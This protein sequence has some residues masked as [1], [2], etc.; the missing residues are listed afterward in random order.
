[1]KTS[2]IILCAFVL[3]WNTTT[4]LAQRQCGIEAEK[5]A[6]IA[7][8]PTW[9]QRFEAQRSSLQGIADNYKLQHG[10]N[11]NAAERTTTTGTISPCPIIFHIVIS[12]ADL[13]L[14]GGYSG[15]QQRVNSQM[16]VINRDFNRQNSDSS[17]IPAGWKSRYGN[18][19]IQ[20][21]LA[22][23][24]PDG[25]ATPGYEVLITNTVFY[26]GTYGDY[27]DAKYSSSGGLDAWDNTK[28]INVWCLNFTNG[29]LGITTPLSFTGSGGVPIA[30]MGIC[31]HFETLGKRASPSD[32]YI[33]TGWISGSDSDYY[34]QGRTLTHEMGHYFEIWHT[35]GDDGG[36][37]PWDSGSDDGLA[38]TPP[39]GDS[40]FYNWPDTIPGGTYYDNCR[41]DT[42]G[43]GDIDTQNYMYGI[44]S[45]DYLNYTDDVAMHMF[46]TM[47]AAAM[48]SMAL[49]PPGSGATGA[50]G[51]G[52]VGETYSVTQ[53]PL[54]LQYPPGTV[55]GV[56]QLEMNTDLNIF[57][58]PATGIINIT[59][60][61]NSGALQ[62]ISVTNMIGQELQNMN[63]SG[64][65][66]NDYSIDLSGMSKG[67]YFVR[68]NFA[69]GIVTR[70]IVLQ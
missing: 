8:D 59:F 47:Q 32:N 34:D 22:H 51:S 17:E 24:A 1:M 61:Q 41:Y 21:G 35:W 14:I 48:A 29:L 27:S 42:A 10:A 6:L 46:T 36:L 50:T 25:S 33:Y 54:L 15:I 31:I 12:S 13:A 63:T 69:S 37:C 62:S 44:A 20:F 55:T 28:Y 30:E 39:E 70:K 64:S 40:H 60:N 43:G 53:N 18:V 23:T 16:A 52:I 5:A 66:A 11:A 58:N 45:L 68:C 2:F 3:C 7:K 56:G 9:K 26:P 57:P 65:Q 38:D 19:G 4:V 49:I 67:I